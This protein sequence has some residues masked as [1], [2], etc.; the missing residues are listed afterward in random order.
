MAKPKKVKVTYQGPGP[1]YYPD[2]QGSGD[3]GLVVAGDEVEVWDYEAESN[4]DYAPASSKKSS[5]TQE[6]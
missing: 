6:G 3:G 4:P 5:S 1:R 2:Q